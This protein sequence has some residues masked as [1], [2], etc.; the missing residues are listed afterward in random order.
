MKTIKLCEFSVNECLFLKL[1]EGTTEEAE[2]KLDI[3]DKKPVAPQTNN[4]T[5]NE[6]DT[7][8]EFL[9]RSDTVVIFPEPVSDLEEEHATSI[10]RISFWILLKFIPIS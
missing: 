7:I 8:K 3:S 6:A 5:S 1:F 4:S 10:G 2:E 9:G